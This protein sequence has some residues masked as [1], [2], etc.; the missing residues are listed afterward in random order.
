L[1][2]NFRDDGRKKSTKLKVDSKW[3]TKKMF[4]RWK[5]KT[6]DQNKVKAKKKKRKKDKS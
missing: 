1:I 6:I 4:Y 5:E 3:A 2:K